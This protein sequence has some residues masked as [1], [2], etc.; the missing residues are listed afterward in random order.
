MS[1]TGYTGH[2]FVVKQ[3]CSCP[4]DPNMEP[5]VRSCRV[6]FSWPAKKQLR[7][8]QPTSSMIFSAN[9]RLKGGQVGV[10]VKHGK[11]LPNRGR[12]RGYG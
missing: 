7:F 2:C 1:I 8:G 9:M 5:V 4:T 6:S 3:D 12:E 10:Q 11:Q